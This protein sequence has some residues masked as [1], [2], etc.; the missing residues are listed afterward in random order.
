MAALVQGCAFHFRVLR[1]K[2]PQLIRCLKV[3]SSPNM[4]SATQVTQR[5]MASGGAARKFFVTPTR[6][7]DKRFIR[8]VRFYVLL[9]AIPCAVGITFINVF[10]GPAQLAEIPEG[11]VPKEYEYHQHPITRF[12]SRHFVNTPQQ[13]YEKM[14]HFLAIEQ[15]KIEA[16]KAEKTVKRLMHQRGDG[17]WYYYPIE[18]PMEAHQSEELKD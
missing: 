4:P 16:R 13:E 2:N 3:N 1:L 6:Y 8:A 9:T 7:A 18:S 15:E 11:Y 17:H 12:L 14:A 5:G 10:I